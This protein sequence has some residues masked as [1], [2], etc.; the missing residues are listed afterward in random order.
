[1][2]E[3]ELNPVDRDREDKSDIMSAGSECL[4]I[5]VYIGGVDISTVG[6]MGTDIGYTDLETREAVGLGVWDCAVSMVVGAARRVVGTVSEGAGDVCGR[7]EEHHYTTARDSTCGGQIIVGGL[8]NSVRRND[9]QFNPIQDG[10]P[11]HVSSDPVPQ[12]PTTAL[13][14]VSLSPG[15]QSQESV[16]QAAEIVTTSNELGLLFSLMFDELLNGTTLVVSK[17]SV[18]YAVDAPNQRQQQN[19]TPS[20]STT[21]DVDTPPLNIQTTPKTTSQAPTVT[22]T[23]NINQAE[24][25]KKLHKLKKKNSS[26]SLVHRYMNKG[27][28]P[29]DM[30]IR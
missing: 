20:T 17:S 22:T 7:L 8:I 27:R 10:C 2:Q 28:H 14:Q 18:V 16:P 23:E 12:C 11:D 9:P 30:L 26:T 6:S 25:I 21:V 1:M 3:Q 15:P 29:P 24:L 4:E 13:E 19:I 5:S